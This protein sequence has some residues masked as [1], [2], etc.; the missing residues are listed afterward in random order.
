MVTCQENKTSLSLIPPGATVQKTLPPPAPFPSNLF[1]VCAL[2]P[3][4]AEPILTLSRPNLPAL[5]SP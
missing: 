5:P 1:D 4:L 2:L 3:Y